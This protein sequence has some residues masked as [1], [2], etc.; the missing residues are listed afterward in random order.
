ME[1]YAHFVCP[2]LINQLT[3]VYVCI[4]KYS[5]V[6]IYARIHAYIHRLSHTVALW[7]S[8]KTPFDLMCVRARS[9][10]KLGMV[11]KSSRNSLKKLGIIRNLCFLNGGERLFRAPAL[12]N[13]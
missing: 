7:W 9:A 11:L 13:V 5:T 1:C 6:F 8:A 3:Y 4:Y 12:L 2:S 10:K